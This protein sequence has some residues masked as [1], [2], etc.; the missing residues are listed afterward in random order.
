MKN[1]PLCKSRAVSKD[2]RRLYVNNIVVI[3]GQNDDEE[4]DAVKKKLEE[5]QR[6]MDMLKLLGVKYC[7]C[8]ICDLPFYTESQ[9]IQHSITYHTFRE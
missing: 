8:N 6:E 9:R 4:L 3:D 1:C 5:L 7:E 2:I